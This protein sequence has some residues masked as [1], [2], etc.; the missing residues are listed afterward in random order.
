MFASFCPFLR[1]HKLS[2]ST[3]VKHFSSKD[4]HRLYPLHISISCSSFLPAYFF[5]VWSCDCP[6][7]NWAKVRPSGNE[8]MRMSATWG[9]AWVDGLRRTNGIIAGRNAK[10]ISHPKSVGQLSF[11][12]GRECRANWVFQT[13]CMASDAHSLSLQSQ[14]PVSIAVSKCFITHFRFW[15]KFINGDK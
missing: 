9:G 1:G 11:L 15:R 2:S 6:G 3:H 14:L 8:T 10:A 12:N 5:F 7:L 4:R 13:Y